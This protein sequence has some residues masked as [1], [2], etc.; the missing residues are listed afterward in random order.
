MGVTN[1]SLKSVIGVFPAI[2]VVKG[3]GVLPTE[4]TDPWMQ[5]FKC[6]CTAIEEITCPNRTRTGWL[7]IPALRHSQSLNGFDVLSL[8]GLHWLDQLEKI[9]VGGADVIDGMLLKAYPA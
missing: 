5:N 2:V 6:M 4:F 1:D 7:D 9:F 3:P 8:V